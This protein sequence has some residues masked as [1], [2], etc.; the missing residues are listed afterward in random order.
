MTAHTERLAAHPNPLPSWRKT[1]ARG[2]VQNHKWTEMVPIGPPCRAMRN[3]D[4]SI[5]LVQ[6]QCNFDG[7]RSS[8]T[9]TLGIPGWLT[10]TFRQWTVESAH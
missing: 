10:V 8:R 1:W 3:R 5:P 7:R 6:K 9:M 2:V 4:P